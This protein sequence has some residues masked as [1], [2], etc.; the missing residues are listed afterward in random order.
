MEI[1]QNLLHPLKTGVLRDGFRAKIVAGI[2]GKPAIFFAAI[3]TLGAVYAQKPASQPPPANDGLACFQSVPI[4]EYPKAAL[5]AHID[6]SI[7]TWTQVTPQG[8][9]GKIDTQVASAWNEASKLLVSPV[10]TALKSAKFKPECAAKTVRAVFRYE[11]E[12]QAAP[13]KIT[14]DRDGDYLVT[15]ESHPAS[16]R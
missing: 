5:D 6:G 11:Y 16:R 13:P 15:I 3:L 9:A 12:G 7:W 10:E 2:M 4:P 8:A 1:L 14:S